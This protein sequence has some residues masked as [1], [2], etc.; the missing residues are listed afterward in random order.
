MPQLTIRHTLLLTLAV[1]GLI[2]FGLITRQAL[3]TKAS[4]DR[5]AWL[6]TTSE[7]ADAVIAA[8]G[9]EAL[10][11]G[12]TARLLTE[13]GTPDAAALEKLRGLRQAGDEAYDTA[14]RLAGSIHTLAI[15]NSLTA[16][17]SER[18]L[19][20]AARHDADAAFAGTSAR[21][22][23]AAWVR[24]MTS[25]IEAMAA[26][27]RSAFVAPDPLDEVY[28]ANVRV[29]DI[30][31]YVSEHAG[32][33]RAAVASAIA[34]R[35]PIPAEVRK[36]LATSR[37]IVEQNLQALRGQVR[38]SGDPGLVQ[39]MDRVE[40]DFLGRFERTR[41]AVYGASD[42]GA[43]YPVDVAT[44]FDDATRGIDAVIGVSKVV[45]EGTVRQTGAA[46]RQRLVDAGVLGALALLSLAALAAAW[47]VIQ[48]RILQPLTVLGAASTAI[49]SG[50]LTQPV[51]AVAPDEIGELAASFE[52]MRTQLLE[53][54][55]AVRTAAVTIAAA[56]RQSSAAVSETAASMEEMA[57]SIQQVSGNALTLAG[58]VEETGATISEMSASIQQVAGNAGALSGA[59]SQ[60]S[61]AIAQMTA[62]AA[63]VATDVGQATDLAHQAARA[64]EDGSQAVGLTVSSMARIEAMMH[65]LSAT[66]EGLDRRATAIG[67]ITA[68]IDDIADQ[69]N[70]LALNAAIE[71]ARAGEHGRGFAVVADEVRKLAISCSEA[72]GK[73]GQQLKDVRLESAGALGATRESEA[74]IAEGARLARQAGES[75]NA[76]VNSSQGVHTLMGQIAAATQ[77]QSA[78]SAQVDQAASHVAT[79]THQV[80]AASQEQAR[81]SSQILEAVSQMTSLT[82]QVSM[83]TQEQRKSGDQVV[84]AVNDIQA[85]ASDLEANGERLLQTVGFFQLAPS[86]HAGTKEARVPEAVPALSATGV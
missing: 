48:R 3:D 23:P 34:S 83:A 4:M 1:L 44:W 68:L 58:N 81:G 72:T 84:Q 22:A 60:T 2:G 64:A 10:E 75:L 5:C 50:D 57:A 51:R 24:T 7:L 76:I 62:A 66:I 39:A 11:R 29:K 33:E 30:V 20:E 56:S 12:L 41:T 65:S 26:L 69:T 47:V 63:Q 67:D 31:Y 86:E 36:S 16:L 71:A 73:I 54:V 45:S 42:R 28:R 53:I 14:V 77:E 13:R 27:R 52:T 6:S 43:P 59:S 17:R 21:P 79:L 38:M 74:A 61:A 18:G 32:R 40:T 15:D 8:A 46:S 37:A 35:R 80:A 82:Q 9:Q 78:A 49:A 19:L 70:L 85:M 55:G 25:Y